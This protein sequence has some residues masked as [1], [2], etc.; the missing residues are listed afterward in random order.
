MYIS[1]CMCERVYLGVS[2]CD[3]VKFSS[4]LC[5]PNCTCVSWAESKIKRCVYETGIEQ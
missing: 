3:E 2:L 4:A 5:N 1:L